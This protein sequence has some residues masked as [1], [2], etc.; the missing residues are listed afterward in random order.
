MTGNPLDAETRSFLCDEARVQQFC[1]ALPPIGRQTVKLTELWSAFLKVY[2]DVPSG[3]ERRRWLLLVLEDAAQRGMIQLP[4]VHGRRWDRSSAVALPTHIRLLGEP[5]GRTD[6]QQWRQFPWH[7][8]LQWVLQLRG[9]SDNQVR[10]LKQVHE[11]LVEGWFTKPECFKYRSLQLTGDEKRLE[12]WLRGGLF[13]PGRLTLEILGCEAEALP[14]AMEFLSRH[15]VMLVFENAAPFMLARSITAANRPPRLGRL[16]YGAGKQILK[17]V[18]YLS[19]VSPAIGE[20]LYVGDL[21]A[22]GMKIAADLQ[23]R[24]RDV[25]VRPAASFHARML[26]SAAAL[27][28]PDG[29][30]AGERTLPKA[31]DSTISFLTPEVRR[32]VLP[33]VQAGRRIP[34]EVLDRA[35]MSELLHTL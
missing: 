11:G 19:M 6:R 23:R 17:A 9:L 10:F 25:V 12:T 7:S 34:E 4:V 1:L 16:A 28:T 13:E 15:P 27:G 8:R 32:C 14:L 31:S 33:I 2:P 35:A 3:A 29:W 18:N 20:V 22:E 26:Y 5:N 24:C 30:P 21:D